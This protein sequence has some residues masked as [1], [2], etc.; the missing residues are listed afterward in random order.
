MMLLQSI[1][2]TKKDTPSVVM[3]TVRMKWISSNSNTMVFYKRN[4]AYRD[5]CLVTPVPVHTSTKL[6]TSLPVDVKISPSKDM[7][8]HT[9]A[10]PKNITS[11]PE[12]QKESVV[13]AFLTLPRSSHQ[14]R[15]QSN[16]QSNHQLRHQLRHQSSHQLPHQFRHQSNHQL[17]HQ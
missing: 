6:T 3:S 8:G 12:T 1:Q 16:L 10:L 17:P 15:H 7:Y 9:S 11:M 14:F 2:R 4:S 13:R 5:T